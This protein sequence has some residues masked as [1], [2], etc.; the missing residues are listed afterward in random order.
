M[1]KFCILALIL[2]FSCREIPKQYEFND[3]CVVCDTTVISN[4]HIGL[5][6]T[7]LEFVRK[8]H[9]FKDSV[10]FLVFGEAHKVRKDTVRIV[11]E[12]YS[13]PNQEFVGI[14]KSKNSDRE[15]KVFKFTDTMFCTWEFFD[16]IYAVVAEW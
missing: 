15:S 2:C 1:K 12:I 13:Y 5:D 9:I 6:N 4:C 16:D 14:I 10:E 8:E 7:V 3:T 11:N